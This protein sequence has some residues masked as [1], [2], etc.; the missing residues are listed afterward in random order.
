MGKYFK[1]SSWDPLLQMMTTG[2]TLIALAFIYYNPT[3]IT[4]LVFGAL[5]LIPPFFMIKGYSIDNQKLIIHRLGWTKEFDIQ[6]LVDVEFNA[7]ALRGSWRVLGNGGLFGWI[8]T[9]SNKELGTFKAYATNQHKCVVLELEEKTLLITP[10]TPD[11]FVEN[12][13]ALLRN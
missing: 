5:V 1:A 9:F 6:N 13:R 3:L 7:Q 2:V 10:E 4:I 12:V 8:G 11:E